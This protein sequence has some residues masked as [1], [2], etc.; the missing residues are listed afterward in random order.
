MTSHPAATGPHSGPS[1]GLAGEL[2]ERSSAG[3]GWAPTHPNEWGSAPIARR[4]AWVRA[5]RRLV[6][7]RAEELTAL[8][9]DE[10]HK[11]PHEA[12]TADLAPLLASCVWHERHAARALRTRAARGTPLWLRYTRVRIE[13]APLG[14]VGII[15][16]WNYPVQLL[17]I[18]L[19]QAL[20]TGNCVVV[21]PSE[22][23]PRSQGLLLDLAERA[24]LPAGVLSR[25]D[26]TRDEGR[27]MILEDHLDHVVF[28]GSTRTGRE[29]ARQAAERLIPT[30][31]ELSGNDSALVLEDADAAL[32][33][34]AIWFAVTANGGQTCMAPRRAVVHRGVYERF[35]AELATLAA[36]ERARRLIDAES[37][38]RCFE[39]VREAIVA[40][41]RSLSGVIE[42]P[43]DGVMRPVAVA[44]CPTG[45]GLVEGDH[46]GPAIAVLPFED[47][48]EAMA[49]HHREHLPG[50]VQHL[51][52]S[53]YTRSGRTA[54]ALAGGLGC[55]FVTVNDSVI[56]QSHPAAAI[57]GKGRSGWG[58]SRGE[59]G[60]L[61]MTRPVAVARSG[62]LMRPPTDPP[63][64][65][66]AR[67]LSGLIRWLYC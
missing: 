66:Q 11:P 58:A 7:D 3:S 47:L 42:A 8:I 25:R 17:G 10:V 28:T 38:E 32:A 54:G 20:V 6:A 36:G 46:F 23:S 50:A 29:I 21:K 16:T 19:V 41:G 15:A 56:P 60:L 4:L 61:A 55:S 59:E 35:V 14:R 30:T 45:C 52:C 31:L 18:Q 2:E 1:T 39:L 9:A 63:T 40:G 33:A 34:R 13:R 22:R 64:P 37:A 12:M 51:S 27:R 65:E 62:R 48:R 44:D 67:R 26:A 5:F 49:I 24:G 57:A 43:R 53:V